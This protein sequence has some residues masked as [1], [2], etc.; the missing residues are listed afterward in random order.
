MENNGK[1]VTII[2]VARIAGFG[3]STVSRVLNRHPRVS[4]EARAQVLK[5]ID[6]LKYTPS[7]TARLLRGKRP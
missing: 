7:E 2:D 3:T 6:E 4:Q 5:V 1:A